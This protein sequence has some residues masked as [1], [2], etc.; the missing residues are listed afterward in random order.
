MEKLNPHTVLKVR[1]HEE[2]RDPW[3]RPTG[4]SL[5]LHRQPFPQPPSRGRHRSSSSKLCRSLELL[6]GMLPLCSSSPSHG[7]LA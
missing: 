2:Q 7:C 4:I 3:D 5:V 1:R 6:P